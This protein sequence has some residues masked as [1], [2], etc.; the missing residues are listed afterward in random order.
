MSRRRRIIP[1]W[2]LP[3]S[4][5]LKGKL[6]ELAEAQY[7]YEGEHLESVIEDIEI[8][9]MPEDSDAKKIATLKQRRK[10]DEITENEYNKEVASI[11]NEP[12]VVVKNI[13]T[14]PES[15]SVG[16][17]ELDWNDAFVEM[18]EDKGYGPALSQEQVVDEWLSELCRNIALDRFDGVGDFSEKVSGDIKSKSQG[19]VIYRNDI[20]KDNE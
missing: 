13:E 10:K 7:Y 11:Q 19:D 14:D 15:P 2:M 4:W 20:E 6:R 17:I 1:F 8:R 5:G 9:H 16:S 18:L 12:W 3:M